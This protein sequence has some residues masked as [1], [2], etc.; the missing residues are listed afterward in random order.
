MENNEVNIQNLFDLYD[1]IGKC[2]SGTTVHDFKKF[3]I[4]RTPHADWP[5]IAYRIDENTVDENTVEAVTAEMKKLNMHPFAI[6]NYVPDAFGKFRKKGFMPIE[7]WTI[8]YKEIANVEADV[9]SSEEYFSH[10]VEENE[11]EKWVELVSRNLFKSKPLEV[12]L[13]SQL[14]ANGAELIG[15]R[16]KE[17]LIGTSMIY[18]DRSGIPGIY[19][20]S[21]DENFRGQGLG[22]A[23]AAF[24]LGRI[25]QKE[26]EICFLQA[27]KIAT[28]LY[29]SMGFTKTGNCFLYWKIK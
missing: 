16:V 10:L 28:P 15:L 25:K 9:N 14:R 18:F 26:K 29:E 24:C 27:T 12:P 21:I 13:F 11:V 20:V 5:N 8:M 2:F 4:V 22:R 23:I 7:Q 3:S 1:D 6:Q 17:E 19:M